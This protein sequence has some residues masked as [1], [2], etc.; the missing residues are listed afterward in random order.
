MLERTIPA[1]V[2]L[3]IRHRPAAL[4]GRSLLEVLDIQE[5]RPGRLR[6]QLEHWRSQPEEMY[7]VRPILAFAAIGQ[8]RADGKITPE[9]ES[10]VIGKLLT[11]RALSGTMEAAEGCAD[12]RPRACHDHQLHRTRSTDF[13]HNEEN[14]MADS[15]DPGEGGVY[16]VVKLKKSQCPCRQNRGSIRF[17][18]LDAGPSAGRNADTRT[19]HDRF[20]RAL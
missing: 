3:L 16:G 1:F 12:S 15:I 14:I 5:L 8:G 4:Q 17:K 2:T 18:G 9:E 13:N 11:H 20:G 6:S 7:R 19:T 10:L